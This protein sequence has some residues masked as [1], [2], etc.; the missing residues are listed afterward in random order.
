[1][2][3]S[4][5]IWGGQKL[6]FECHSYTKKGDQQDYSSMGVKPASILI[7]QGCCGHWSDLQIQNVINKTACNHDGDTAQIEAAKVREDLKTKAAN[8]RGTPNHCLWKHHPKNPS[9]T[10]D[11]TINDTW[12]T[13]GDKMISYTL[14]GIGHCIRLKWLRLVIECC[15]CSNNDK[16]ANWFSL[17]NYHRKKGQMSWGG[18]NILGGRFISLSFVVSLIFH[19]IYWKVW[20]FNILISNMYSPWGHF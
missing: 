6:C 18:A 5:S 17:V 2:E 3:I 12:K 20:V 10:T 19:K 16:T 1:M 4:T 13:T 15:Y 7:M 11:L 8:T 14:Q 9:S